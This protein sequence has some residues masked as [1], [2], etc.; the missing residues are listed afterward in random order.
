MDSAGIT[1][2]IGDSTERL[3]TAPPVSAAARRR[4]RVSRVMHWFRSDHGGLRDKVLRGS[5]W[6]LIGSMVNRFAG[7]LKLAVLGR[8]LSPRDFGLM[9]LAMIGLKWLEYFSQSG[10]SAALIHR[11]DDITDYLDSAFAVQVLRSTL[12]ATGLAIG[13]PYIAN[14]FATPASIPV[15]RGVAVVVFLRGFISPAVV[16]L[17]KGLDL[18]KEVL[19]K[20]SSAITGLAVAVAVAIRV[21]NV[22][23]L[24]AS[25]IAAQIADTTVSYVV[26]PYRPRL[27]FSWRKMR[28][29]TKFGK[30]IFW[31]NIWNFIRLY[32][33]NMVTAKVLG[34]ITLGYYDMSY[35]FAVMMPSQ[36]AM[37]MTGVLFPAF[38]K[39]QDIAVRR[40]GYLQMLRLSFTVLIPLA[41][42]I[43]LFP[44]MVVRVALGPKWLSMAPVIQILIWAGMATVMVLTN[45]A[46]LNATGRPGLSARGLF[47]FVAIMGILLY[48]GVKRFG[49]VGV[50]IAVTI[51]AVI[52]ASHQIWW[53]LRLVEAPIWRVLRCAKTGLLA[54]IP[55]VALRLLIHPT[56]THAHIAMVIAASL[57]SGAFLGYSVLGQLKG[58]SASKPAEAAA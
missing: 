24:V 54:S 52:S 32:G 20:F 28:E 33:D 27:R 40:R 22:W 26:T 6:L 2:E 42:G 49:V 9:S 12:L 19:W 30:W 56:L 39:L 8:L 36:L 13:A 43:S 21:R 15:I 4:G 37:A 44:L 31:A 57:V 58:R 50:A 51:A 16:Y 5:M 7:M 25:V 18:R 1:T 48:P 45:N 55:L 47:L 17:R 23:A 29:L 10:F 46:V 14:F 38:S 35:Q 41:F 53:A 34:T 11:Q 3:A